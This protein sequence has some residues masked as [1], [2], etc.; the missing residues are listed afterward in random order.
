MVL[1]SHSFK[2]LVVDDEPALSELLKFDFES[3][4][5]DVTVATSFEEAI[6]CFSEAKP[7][8]IISDVRMPG[9]D[10]LEL[11]KYVKGKNIHL[12]VIL[13]TGYTHNLIHRFFS[14]GADDV[15]VKPI[16]RRELF[17]AASELLKSDSEAFMR[18]PPIKHFASFNIKLEDASVIYNCPEI[19][20]GRKG[21]FLIEGIT[22][23][24]DDSYI[25][26]SLLLDNPDENI[27]I[28]G[29]IRFRI[30]KSG[31]GVQFYKIMGPGKEKFKNYISKL[32]SISGIPKQI[33]P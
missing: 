30:E 13:M 33:K 3:K 28:V 23:D 5:A 8:L 17:E 20:W 16:V 27:E 4:G 32:E 9:R 24:V 19:H 22:D 26:I 7:D 15:F 6:G 12:P 14:E 29:K 2:I 11:L 25:K 1:N 10:G 21:F 18:E 31:V